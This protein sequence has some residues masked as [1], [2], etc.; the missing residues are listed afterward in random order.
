MPASPG[1]AATELQTPTPEF[2]APFETSGTALRGLVLVADPQ[3]SEAHALAEKGEEKIAARRLAYA[4]NFAIAA[5][6]RHHI[7][8]GGGKYYLTREDDRPATASLADELTR[9]QV[10]ARARPH[11]V[12]RISHE[13]E[14]N[15]TKPRIIVP[16][17]DAETSDPVA[18]S[19]AQALA[20]SFLRLGLG[21]FE[22]EPGHLAI[23]EQTGALALEIIAPPPPPGK[24]W[25]PAPAYT[26]RFAQA[27]YETFYLTWPSSQLGDAMRTR[28]QRA[29]GAPPVDTTEEKF[30]PPDG[31]TTEAAKLAQRLWPFPQPPRDQTEA[32]YLLAAYQR[33]LTDSTFF[34]LDARVERTASG[35][36]FIARANAPELA[37]TAAGILRTAGCNPL[38]TEVEILPSQERLGGQ[39]FAVT[40][41]TAA[42]T[43]GAP[44]EGNNVQTQLLPGEPVWLL[45]RTPDGSFFLV[46]GSDGYVGWVRADAIAPITEEQFTDLLTSRQA[47]LNAPWSNRLYAL[48]PGTRLKLLEEKAAHGSRPAARAAVL[49]AMPHLVGNRVQFES[50]SIPRQLLTLSPDLRAGQVAVDTALGLY[51][52]PYVFG[53]RSANGLDCSGLVGVSYEAAGLRL[54]RDARQMVLV[55]RLVATRWHRAALMPGDILFFIDKTGRVV[56]TGLSL[57]GE[58]FVHSCPPCVRVNSFLPQDPLYSKTWHQTFIFARRPSD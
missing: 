16:S 35:W 31:V 38:S 28:R 53:G 54:P 25:R 48:S 22:I 13:S 51:G 5:L 23:T 1:S 3:G 47:T 20:D 29:L 7:T 11:C 8:D 30:A 18:A 32:S 33:Q 41:Q 39:L 12:L 49:V 37:E 42:L 44:E 2:T 9:L 40:L 45:D 57:G 36:R 24:D 58:R 50:L 17:A 46:Q 43:W 14:H 52:T 10:I 15:R 4:T 26:H 21:R 27:I 19:L 55:G 6:L 56:H 34:Y